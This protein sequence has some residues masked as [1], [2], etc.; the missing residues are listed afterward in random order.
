MGEI[1][2]KEFVTSTT[3]ANLMAQLKVTE[4]IPKIVARTIS[5]AQSDF[6]QHYVYSLSTYGSTVLP[7]LTE[8]ERLEMAV[9]DENKRKSVRALIDRARQGK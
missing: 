8:L 5:A 2:N 9:S 7:Y 1:D 3:A 4:A 6:F